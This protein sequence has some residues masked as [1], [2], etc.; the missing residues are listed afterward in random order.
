M[1]I[2]SKKY[3]SYAY[4]VEIVDLVIPQKSNPYRDFSQLFSFPEYMSSRK[5]DDPSLLRI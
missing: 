1:L 2:A 5:P 3:R 4:I